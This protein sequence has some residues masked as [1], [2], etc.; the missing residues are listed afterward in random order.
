MWKSQ[1]FTFCQAAGA[2]VDTGETLALQKQQA[3]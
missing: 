1:K 3:S 2:V